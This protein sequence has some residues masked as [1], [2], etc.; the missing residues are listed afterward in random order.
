MKID[1]VHPVAHP[2][3]PVAAPDA[4]RVQIAIVNSDPRALSALD[5]D[6]R[7]R[8][9]DV[10]SHLRPESA[11]PGLIGGKAEVALLDM[12]TDDVDAYAVL[13]RLR[14]HSSLP[15]VILT[16]SEDE[17]EEIVGLR[18]GADAVVRRPWSPQLLAERIRALSRRARASEP[19]RSSADSVI[20]C[21]PLEIDT[22]RMVASWR[23]AALHLTATEFRLLQTLAERPGYVRTRDF[24]MDRLYGSD[25]FVLDR[26]VDSHVKR[27]RRKMRDIDPGFDAIET[28]YGTG[29][30]LTLPE[31]EA[32]A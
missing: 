1:T 32:A 5:R 20:S 16:D 29:Y 21:P 24:L 14:E 6:L 9:F 19:G 27:L 25:I 7:R 13:R 18:M 15:V 4:Q 2:V 3:G 23:G 12:R 28:L 30:R 11:L 26:T 17:V 10:S 8:G 22:N 31:A